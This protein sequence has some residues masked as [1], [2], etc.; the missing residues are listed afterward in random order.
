MFSTYPVV[1]DHQATVSMT[2][3]RGPK[4][5]RV[6]TNLPPDSRAALPRFPQSPTGVS[7]IA[8]ALAGL[9]HLGAVF[10]GSCSR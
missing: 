7:R 6:K 1:G 10:G 3:N 2:E 4:I 8:V 9:P 5:G